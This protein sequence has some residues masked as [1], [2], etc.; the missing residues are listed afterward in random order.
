MT[1]ELLHAI[2]QNSFLGFNCAF[3]HYKGH[4]LHAIWPDEAFA[5]S[6]HQ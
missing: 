4:S 3:V 6:P 5:I 1:A 2:E